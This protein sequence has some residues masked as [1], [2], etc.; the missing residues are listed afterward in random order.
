[1]AACALLFA[2]FI[3][4][5]GYPIGNYAFGLMLSIH[6]TGFVY[7]CSPYLLDNSFCIASFLRCWF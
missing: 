4:W 7:Y 6:T 1:M 3:V 2:I 5:L